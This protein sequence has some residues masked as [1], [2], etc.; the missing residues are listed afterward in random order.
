MRKI[1]FLILLLTLLP[2]VQLSARRPVG[3]GETTVRFRQGDPLIDPDFSDNR[4]VLDAFTKMIKGVLESKDSDV[5]YILV[6]T[7]ASPEGDPAA[8]DAL[9]V[10]RA[11]SIHDYLLTVLP[12]E[13]AQIKIYSRG[14][15]WHGFLELTKA[16]DTKWKDDILNAL[17][18]SG[19]LSVNS[20]K[21]QRTCLKELKRIDNGAAWAYLL[22]GPFKYLRSS[23]ATINLVV[24]RHLPERDTIVVI[25]EYDGPDADWYLGEASRVAAEAATAAATAAATVAAT[26]ASTENVLRALNKVPKKRRY[27]E[28]WRTPVFAF[29]T[30]LLL[31]LLNAGFEVPLGNRWSI[32]GDA[33]WPWAWR[34]WSNQ[35]LPS[36]QYCY[37]TMSFSLGGRYWFGSAHQNKPEYGKYRMTGH[38]LGLIVQGGYYDLCYDWKGGQGEFIAVGLGYKYGLPVGKGGVRFEFELAAGVAYTLWRG[39][40]VH[41][42][43]GR[44][45]GNWN[46]GARFVPVP[47]RLGVNLVVPIFK[48]EER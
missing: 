14:I 25:H 23:S 33:Y 31:P 47:V 19:V 9:A 15:D 27:D 3:D 6:E 17:Y 43:A 26:E 2:A 35:V 4:K 28:Y 11:R 46:D 8:N 20:Y 44:L 5:E 30:N 18:R 41:E 22:D 40:E 13:S 45:I 24:K 42:P 10:R 1:S 48:K 12:L 39:Y 29:T 32:E 38:S 7:T 16:S 36:Q 34:L 37:Q 21:E